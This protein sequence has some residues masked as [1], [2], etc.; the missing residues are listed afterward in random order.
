MG[1]VYRAADTKLGREVA[2]KVLPESLASDPD[3][4]ARFER[5]ARSLAALNH[6]NI[7]TIYA[8]EEV[9]GIRFLA[10]ELV[11]GQ[12]LDTLIPPGG[13]APARFFELA[14]PL[15]EAL[16]AAHERGIV[17]RDLKPGN[18]MVT[19]EGRVKVLDFGLAK[20]EAADSNPNLTSTPT[21]S[22][23]ADLTSEGQVFGTVAYM[24][25]EQARGARVDSRSDVFSLGVVLYQMATG[26]RPF[27]GTT[28][29]DLISSIL[30]DTPAAVTNLRADLPPH[31]SRVLRRCLEKEP[32]DRYQTSRDVYNELRD[33]REETSASSSSP[34]LQSAPAP[35]IPPSS[36]DSGSRRADEG[37]WLA[38]L[39]FKARGADA[40][41]QA[42][43]EGLTEEIVTGL[44]RFSYLKVI[45]RGSTAP[46]S[47]EVVDVRAV[48][49]ELGARY[50]MEGSLRRSGETLRVSAQ[51]VDAVSGAHLWAETYDR[52]YR[53]E[54]SFALQDDVVRRIVSTIADTHGILPHSM[55]EALRGKSP[56]ALTPYEAVLR[57][58]SQVISVSAEEHASV[59]DGL[60][61]AVRE[62]PGYAD[63]WALLSDIYREE[64]AHG[65]NLRPDP[66]GRALAAARRAV[67]IAPSNHLAYGALATAHFLRREFPAFR[68]A[69]ERAIALNPM[70]G[71]TLAY[72]GVLV[73]YSG[74]WERG[75]AM[76]RQAR[77]LNPHHPTWYWFTDCFDA[78]RR[79]DYRAALDIARRIQMPGFWRMNLALAVANGQ[80]GERDAAAAAL[81][82]L[83]A[84]RPE[85]ASR[86]REELAKWWNA[87]FVE[88]LMDGLRKAGLD[89]R[90]E[91]VEAASAP[92]PGASAAAPGPKRRWWIA[93]AIAATTIL[94][95]AAVWI[96]RGRTGPGR[97]PEAASAPGA[98][99][100]IAVLPLDNYSGD[101]SQDYFAEGMTDELTSD[102]A[103]ISQLRVIS[104][105]SAMQFKGKHRPPT[106]EIAKKLNVD[107]IVEGSVLRSGDKVRI[108]AQLIDARAD[109]HLWA[110]SFERNSRDVL[111]LQ[112]ELASAIAREIHVQLTP[113]EQSRLDA[114]RRA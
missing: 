55:S 66:L 92:A 34:R 77:D 111:A 108:T 11:E 8:V 81:R 99:R 24:S 32:R 96:A 30:R 17:H 41:V 101:P 107:A 114:A 75:C 29:V 53:P 90:V 37:F 31:L 9:D 48:G 16:S 50:V 80:V 71:Y 22:R 26:E 14:V 52:T 58:L 70:D 100:S 86:A 79:G 2:I 105:G 43:A 23:A 19:G 69:T 72:L 36:A 84:A 91:A 54:S 38:V 27:R 57:G 110:K 63:A 33:L 65:F 85:F 87:D 45:A 97:L 7:V 46:F 73:A 112:D 103:N 94:L 39:P 82:E 21:E 1:E 106:P 25:P 102:L 13:L 35:S 98:I 49:R 20:V 6:P 5:E 76:Q 12:S 44:S 74:D 95:A 62:A 40:E 93:A 18:V 68:S 67:E 10:M 64:Y 109:R 3:R 42:L 104:R 89:V 61:R 47:D 113:A 56:D 28:A 4:L 59:R 51:L 60:E 78:Y 83:L 88:H 15:A